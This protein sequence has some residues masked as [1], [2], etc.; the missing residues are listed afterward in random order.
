MTQ[1]EAMDEVLAIT[2]DWAVV[3]VGFD[4]WNSPT[5][6]TYYITVFAHDYEAGEDRSDRPSCQQF[7]GEVLEEVVEDAKVFARQEYG[8][9]NPTAVVNSSHE[10]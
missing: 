9:Q 7:S 1:Q 2:G 3:C 4:M 8:G 5:R 6:V 10:E